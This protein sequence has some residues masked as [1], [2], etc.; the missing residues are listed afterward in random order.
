MIAHEDVSGRQVYAYLLYTYVRFLALGKCV[1]SP[2]VLQVQTHSACNGGC[3]VCPYGTV[4]KRL[5]QGT[6]EWSLFEKIAR[7]AV[8]EPFPQAVWFVLQNEPLLDKRVFDCVK[9]IKST[10]RGKFCAICTNGALLDAFNSTD[11]VQSGLD[12][13]VISLDAHSRET[14]ERLHGGLSYDRVIKNI[15]SMLSNDSLR[16]RVCLSF[17]ATRHNLDEVRV[18]TRYWSSQGVRTRVVAVANRAGALEG[19]ESIA[20][21]SHYYGDSLVSSAWGHLMH[22]VPM[23]TG[24]AHPFHQM[25]ILFN[26]DC[27]VCCQDWNRSTVV[28]NAAT[29]PLKDIWNSQQM[30]Q[31]RRRI[32]RKQYDRIDACRGC[33]LAR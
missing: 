8:S 1:G 25:N 2:L 17:L 33:S 19:Y 21:K 6:M 15:S 18:A 31:I 28:G 3:L 24:C 13:L 12:L 7:Q 20:P 14:Y 10:G 23:V 5:D 30:N 29:T 27:I 32:L 11:M 4:S 22:G 16:H 26:G 9:F